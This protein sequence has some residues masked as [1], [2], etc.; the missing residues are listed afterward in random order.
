MKHLKNNDLTLA[1]SEAAKNSHFYQTSNTENN[2]NPLQSLDSIPEISPEDKRNILNRLAVCKL[3]GGLGTSMGCRGPKSLIEVRNGKSFM[4]FVLEQMTVSKEQFGGDIP[5]LLMNSFYTDKDTV[6]FLEQ[7]RE[8][9][10]VMPFCQNKFHRL[11]RRSMLPL[12]PKEFGDEAFYPPGHGD[13]YYCI[14]KSGLLDKLIRAGKDYIFISNIDNLGA[15]IDERI[16]HFMA[17]NGIAFLCEVADKT[18]ADV[19]GGTFVS[20]EG[21]G[22]SLLEQTQTPPHFR[23]EFEKVSRFKI[24]NTN[25]LWINLH[26]LKRLLSLQSVKTDLIFNYKQVKETDVVQLET[27]IASAISSFSNSALLSVPRSRFIPVKKTEDL[28]LVRSNLF[29][30]TDGQLRVNPDRQFAHLPL[31]RLGKYFHTVDSLEARMPEIPDILELDLLTVVGDVRFGRGVSLIANVIITCTGETLTIPDR[32]VLNNKVVYG[33]EDRERDNPMRME[34]FTPDARKIIYDARRRVKQAGYKTLEPEYLFLALLNSDNSRLVNL[35]KIMGIDCPRL[36]DIIET[37]I[38]RRITPIVIDEAQIYLS[39]QTELLIKKAVLEADDMRSDKVDPIHILLAVSG[40]SGQLTFELVRSRGLTRQSIS[41][42]LRKLETEEE[43]TAA[44][45]QKKPDEKKEN[46]ETEVDPLKKYCLDLLKRARENRFDPVFGRDEEV[47][48]LIQVLLRRSKNNPVLIGHS[49]VGKTA[50]VEGLAQRIISGDVPESLKNM[51]LYELDLAS[52]I[53]GAR[54]RGDFEDRLK[55]LLAKIESSNRQIILFI[56]ELHI[57]VGAGATDG[58]MDASNMLKPALARGELRCVGATTFDEYKKYI[59]KDPA[60]ARRFQKVTVKEPDTEDCISMLRNLKAKYEVHHGVRIKDAAIIAAV[61]LSRRY[62]TDRFLPD[63]AI[64]LIDESASK[65][66][67]EIDSMPTELDSTSRRLTQLEIEKA[68]LAKETDKATE[69]RTIEIEREILHLKEK[70]TNLRN[71]WEEERYAIREIKKLKEQI[72]LH[73]QEEMEAVRLGD[74]ERAARIKYGILDELEKKLHKLNSQ[75]DDSEKGRI[76]REEVGEED[77]AAILAKW[78]GIPISKM[79]T[80]EREKLLHMEDILAKKIIGQQQA[81]HV[82]SNSIRR[83]R[84]GI[85][86]P[87]RPWGCFLFMGPTGVGKTELVK[88]LADFLF[89]DMK[90]IIRLDMSEYMEKHAVSRLIG[91]PPGYVGFEE[92]GILTEAVRQKPYA[93]VL[94]DEIEKA[95][96]EIFNVLLQILD[97]G[98]LTDSRG[99]T[100]NFKN[101]IIILTTNIG[102]D[103][104]L[105][106]HSDYKSLRAVLMQHFKPEFINRLDEIVPFEPLK[107][108]H[109][110]RIVRLQA[111]KLSTR[112]EEQKIKFDLAEDAE[113][114]LADA[115]YD[116]EFGARPIK[117]LMQQEIENKIAFLMTEGSIKENSRVIAKIYQDRLSI[118]YS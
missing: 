23:K 22:I 93:V 66:R 24:F 26:E 12:D 58:A 49:G 60:L 55:L 102:S 18:R 25:N 89:N 63:K 110:R 46:E 6:D 13:F 17:Q 71:R 32:A 33:M 95:H 68:A 35:F 76:L 16:P 75:M 65:L 114:Y 31:I 88:N 79:L 74:L 51:K 105:G 4:D 27:A 36:A 50:I 10:Q 108:E 115:G 9:V 112:L 85:Q 96:R 28:M 38:P 69:Q 11:D 59:E 21:G 91:A 99:N 34:I 29:T 1:I 14:E 43:T 64:D 84:A 87:V 56:D 107:S 83:A 41:G 116:A 100:I 57:L 39:R 15:V 20:T 54:Y 113:I 72:E 53:A 109:I 97:E 78:T 111:Q 37:R 81:I 70:Y 2:I 47:R 77:I 98:H 67:I 106:G 94:F 86:D 80:Q 61:R 19:K 40:T 48:L 82:V 101:T 8:T 117:R 3:N 7:Y 52:M 104:L 42:A 62:I 118:F 73:S 92:G 90:A 5:L 45:T 30:E 44:Q 103:A